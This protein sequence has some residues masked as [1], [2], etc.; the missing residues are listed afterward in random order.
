MRGGG[1]SSTLLSGAFRR[2]PVRVCV[3]GIA[4]HLRGAGGQEQPV[5]WTKGWTFHEGQAYGLG[6]HPTHGST[7][8]GARTAD[9]GRAPHMRAGQTT[10]IRGRTFHRTYEM[11][12]K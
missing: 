9:R 7:Q 10:S 6:I 1:H 11:K 3:R 12:L 5:W 8:Q 4:G 2:L